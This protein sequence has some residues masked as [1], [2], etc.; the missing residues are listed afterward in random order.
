M[1]TLFAPGGFRYA[2]LSDAVPVDTSTAAVPAAAAEGSVSVMAI[3]PNPAVGLVTVQL[4]DTACLGGLLDVY[5]LLGQRTMSV[6]VTAL[7]LQLDVA[8]LASGIYFIRVSD[9][10][11]GQAGKLIKV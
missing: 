7:T 1:L 3:Y 11:K 2:L 6:R 5:N 8:G 10:K 4:T 9:G